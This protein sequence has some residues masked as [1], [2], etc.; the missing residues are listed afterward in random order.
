MTENDQEKAEKLGSFISSVFTNQV[1]GMWNIANKPGISFQLNL[2]IDEYIVGKKIAKIKV[3]KLPGPDQ[4]HPRILYET[5]SVLIKAL[6]LMYQTSVR[7]GTLPSAWKN[8][9]ITAIHQ[10]ENRH[11]AGNYRP[12]E[13]H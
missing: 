12:S 5:G 13:S 3:I 8:A 4:M 2:S 7:K 9:N 11:V 10:K 1:E 6:T